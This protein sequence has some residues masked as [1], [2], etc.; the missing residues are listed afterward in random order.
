MTCAWVCNLL[1]LLIY[2]DTYISVEIGGVQVLQLLITLCEGVPEPDWVNICQCHMFLDNAEAVS[3][4]LRKLMSTGG[5]S[6]VAAAA[7]ICWCSN[8][9]HFICTYVLGGRS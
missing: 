1:L 5:V 3:A 4:I 8:H 2:I 9:L 6:G 7:H